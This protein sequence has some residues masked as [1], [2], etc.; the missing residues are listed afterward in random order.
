MI[1]DIA[2]KKLDNQ[3]KPAAEPKDDSVIFYFKGR[4][5][6]VRRDEGKLFPTFAQLGRPEGCVYLFTI[7]RKEFFLLLGDAE[8]TAPEGFDYEPIRSIREN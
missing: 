1:Q 3:Y 4:D 7:G 8:P 6:L 5:V 2:P